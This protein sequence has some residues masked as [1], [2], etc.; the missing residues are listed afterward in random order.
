MQ[1]ALPTQA[2][3]DSRELLYRYGTAIGGLVQYGIML[4]ILALIARKIPRRTLGFI[5]PA[6]WRRAAVLIA[7]ALVAAW[8]IGAVLNI[9]LKAGEEQ[10]LT[11][12]HWEP[13][14]AGAFLANALV[15]V[16]VAPFVEEL[17]Y[18]RRRVRHPPRGVGGWSVPSSA[19]A[20]LFGL[21]H[22]LDRRVADADDLRRSILALLRERTAS[23]YPPM[24][25]H[26]LFNG[27]A[28]LAAV[29]IGGQHD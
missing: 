19:T 25:T 11:P 24:I 14:H 9:F 12:D 27:A 22:G 2:A 7:A 10:G 3:D 4:A 6:S 8:L 16:V 20:L 28:L 5:A 17:M 29:T 23:L 1:H 21:G 18:R 13:A 26:A 15:I